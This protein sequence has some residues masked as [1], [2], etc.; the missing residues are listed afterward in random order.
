MC[1][2]MN[3]KKVKFQVAWRTVDFYGKIYYQD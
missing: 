1:A 2:R 3:E